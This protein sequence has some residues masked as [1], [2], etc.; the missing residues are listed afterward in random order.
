[1]TRENPRP[2]RWAA[3]LKQRCPSCFRGQVFT[4]AL[5]MN[6]TC[7]VCGVRFEREPGYFFGAMYFS[8]A[9]GIPI[10]AGL[11]AT[12]AFTIL[13]TWEL[14]WVA[15]SAWAIYLLL[16]PTVFRYSRILWMH[17]DRYFAPDA[18]ADRKKGGRKPGNT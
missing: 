17:F 10:I 11:T 7:P 8:Y 15:L 4:G 12:L 5:A 14:H 1:M 2:S 3:I 13:R 9:L 6:E 16:V 18:P